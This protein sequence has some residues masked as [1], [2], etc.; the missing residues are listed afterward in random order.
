[1]S[2]SK[3]KLTAKILSLFCIPSFIQ[4]TSL[5]RVPNDRNSFFISINPVDEKMNSVELSRAQFITLMNES[6]QSYLRSFKNE[7]IDSILTDLKYIRDL[8][9]VASTLAMDWKVTGDSIISLEYIAKPVI[10]L[11]FMHDSIST[12]KPVWFDPK[13]VW[14]TTDSTV[15]M[16]NKE[17]EANTKIKELI[18]NNKID[19]IVPNELVSDSIME[20][21]M[22]AIGCLIY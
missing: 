22:P 9:Y 21:I 2:L 17:Y 16:E 14:I 15:C 3:L 4:A 7:T 6:K 11:I 13:I 10:G 12:E 5:S 1:M 8:D 19:I 20:P 18:D